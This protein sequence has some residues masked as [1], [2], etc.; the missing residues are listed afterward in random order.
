MSSAPTTDL[1]A[2]GPRDGVSAWPVRVVTTLLMLA[3]LAVSG[4]AAWLWASHGGTVFFDM[5]VTGLRNCF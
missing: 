2:N 1:A 4:G 3:A 5:I